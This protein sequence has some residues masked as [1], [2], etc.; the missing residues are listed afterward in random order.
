MTSDC[1][2]TL[3]ETGERSAEACEALRAELRKLVNHISAL[4]MELAIE[5]RKTWTPLPAPSAPYWRHPKTSE[6]SVIL[7]YTTCL[8]PPS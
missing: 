5:R 6:P 2:V 4:E 1:P 8:W 3:I 7:S